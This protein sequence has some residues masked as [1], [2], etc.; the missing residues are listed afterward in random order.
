MFGLPFTTFTSLYYLDSIIILSFYFRQTSDQK[1]KQTFNSLFKFSQKP[2]KAVYRVRLCTKN[3]NWS[4]YVHYI[5]HPFSLILC[6]CQSTLYE[7]HTRLIVIWHPA[8]CLKRNI[9]I[10]RRCVKCITCWWQLNLKRG[11]HN[12]IGKTNQF[13]YAQ[14]KI[15]L[16]I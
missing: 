14:Y 2:G 11:T 9:F 16:S 7:G 5:K 3:N 10:H 12:L 6:A 8:N 4:L 1:I 13:D 15:L